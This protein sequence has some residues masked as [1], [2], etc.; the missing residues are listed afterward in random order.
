MGGKLGL[1]H[2]RKNTGL[3][4]SKIIYTDIFPCVYGRNMELGKYYTIK[5]FMVLPDN[6]S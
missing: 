3:G 1:S 4:Y 6:L 5:S 2:Q